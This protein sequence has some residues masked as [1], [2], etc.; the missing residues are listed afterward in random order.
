MVGYAA[1]AMDAR[2][3]HLIQALRR[4]QQHSAFKLLPVLLLFLLM[5]SSLALLSDA[6]QNSARFER[7]YL[8]LLIINLLGALI[9]LFLIGRRIIRF[10]KE[11]R[12]GVIGSRL[13]LRLLSMFMLVSIVPV[14]AVYYFSLQFLD[15]GIDNWFNLQIETALQDALDLS[16]D[17]MDLRVK[18]LI[19]ST[20]AAASSL[21]DQPFTTPQ[22]LT[23]L[24]EESGSQ[25]LTLLT[26]NGRVL[27]NSTLDGTNII[28]QI[29]DN[30]I[31]MQVRQGYNYVD[32]EPQQREQLT[33]RIVTLIETKGTP[34]E[35]MVLQALYPIPQGIGELL[36]NVNDAFA[37][38]KRMVYLREPLKNSFT[39]TLS[40]VLLLTLLTAVW[41]ALFSSQRLVEPVRILALGT[42][43][44]AAGDYNQQL[45]LTSYD[46]FGSLVN[47]FNE[48]TRKIAQARDEVARSQQQTERERSYLKVVLGG[49]TSGVIT[50]DHRYRI[51]TVNAATRQ[52]LEA[53][54]EPLMGNSLSLLCHHNEHLQ[55]F[56]SQLMAQ[57]E[58][59]QAKWQAQITI[60][61][62][63]GRRILMCHGTRLSERQPNRSGHVVVIDDI[64][65]ML[66]AQRDAAWS[67]V[68]RRLAHEIKNPLTPIQLAAE[69]LRRRYLDI[70]PE[71]DSQ[72]LERSTHTIIQQVQ[73]MEEMVKA[74]SDYA[75]TPKRQVVEFNLNQL[76]DEVVELYRGNNTIDFQLQLDQQ[77][78]LIH[79]DK[80]RLRQLLHN[81]LKNAQEALDTQPHPQIR[82]ISE[83]HGSAP[84]GYVV[85]SVEDNGPGIPKTLLEQ[86]FEPY[87]TNKP[88]G[89]G[90]G[91]AI[92]KKI[93]EEHGGVVRAGNRASGGAYINI[94]LP[95]EYNS[96]PTT[97]T[98]KDQ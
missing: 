46:E 13:A 79:G 58:K 7:L 21:Q 63:Q 52:L 43:S 90:L 77:L 61:T 9:L 76:I 73:A 95:L 96:P 20:K 27:A 49:L 72:L 85:L 36:N 33:V 45:P 41:V 89:T 31:L 92:V 55:E 74:F 40:L 50:L 70:L 38:Y 5:L 2:Y 88:K 91:L 54:F 53:D 10:I 62:Q 25:E 93:I 94:R 16:R 12:A 66:T 71:E 3:Q 47:S 18:Q 1:I 64:T 82:I 67:E 48:M 39:L 28:P 17:T 56:C 23:N 60:F 14:S 32:L 26:P 11:F 19:K 97:L 75:Y 69:R 81:L 29:P 78:E 22:Q 6:T 35:S 65:S 80:G 84:S 44:V 37:N 98:T 8:Q 15:K 34:Y 51:R 59:Q 57:F 30:A 87:V 68:A 86:L 83:L 4:L 42:R 24:L